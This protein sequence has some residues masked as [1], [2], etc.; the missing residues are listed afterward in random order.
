[1]SRPVRPVEATPPR[2][3]CELLL[4]DVASLLT[5]SRLIS[6]SLKALR[7]NCAFSPDLT[8]S[9]DTIVATTEA[10]E[11][12]LQNPLSESGTVLPNTPDTDGDALR[13]DF[14][15]RIPAQAAHDVM[16]A[17]V[18]AN[19][20]LLAQHLEF[21]TRL[22]AEEALLVGQ[23]S[24]CRAL[25]GWAAEWHACSRALR[26]ATVRTRARAYFAEWDESPLPIGA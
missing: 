6:H 10:G 3:L 24:L 12:L 9:L 20:H 8:T 18:D 23:N 7:P 2:N 1:M 4:R 21:K 26:L 16:A 17:D 13:T 19:L 5:M 15:T 25:L 11:R 14:F 22:A